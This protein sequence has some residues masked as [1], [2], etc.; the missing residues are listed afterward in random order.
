MRPHIIIRYIGLVLLLSSGFMFV[1]FLI[2]AF[3]AD[4]GRLPLLLSTILTALTGVFP[5]IFVPSSNQVSHKEGYVIVVSSWLLI[6]FFG[7]LPYLLWGG[8]F[9]LANAWF[10]SVS[11]FTTTGS[12]ILN[13]I[14]ALPKGLLFW[15]S[16]THW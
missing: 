14:E 6:C 8:E 4:S 15:R 13:D 11:G 3:N 12:T 2:S 1:S 10:E 16:A 9:S 5:L 7:M